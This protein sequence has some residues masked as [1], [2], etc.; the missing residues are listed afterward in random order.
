MESIN[1]HKI[2]TKCAILDNKYYIIKTIGVGASGKVKL[3]KV[4][5]S[6][7]MVAIKILKQDNPKF[8]SLKDMF[9]NEIKIM[10]LVSNHEN[11]VRFVD[12]R[13]GDLKAT[14]GKTVKVIY[15]VT[16][17]SAGGEL[18]DYIEYCGT[19]PEGIAK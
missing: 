15:I 5:H 12:G 17:Y 3:G 11:I 19:I 2:D 16:E 4:I 8:D 18:M 6:Y 7:Q 1:I 10:K 9:M 14:N 13:V